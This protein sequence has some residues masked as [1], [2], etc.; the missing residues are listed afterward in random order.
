MLYSHPWKDHL[1]SHILQVLHHAVPESHYVSPVCP[2]YLLPTHTD[3]LYL[4]QQY[5]PHLTRFLSFDF[6]VLHPSQ[7]KHA[8]QAS[9]RLMNRDLHK[10]DKYWYS[11]ENHC[12]P[13]FRKKNCYYCRKMHC[14]YQS[15]P[16]FPS[17]SDCHPHEIE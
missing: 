12:C 13:S 5:K 2:S 3:C 8:G 9:A 4:H 1:Q 14:P 10:T 17:R 15:F 7:Y 16:W 6:P 11:S